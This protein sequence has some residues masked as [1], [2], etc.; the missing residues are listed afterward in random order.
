MDSEFADFFLRQSEDS[1][2]DFSALRKA[3]EAAIEVD[4]KHCIS[5]SLKQL[6]TCSGVRCST[7]GL[8]LKADFFQTR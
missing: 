8:A 1:R 5:A 2:L 4:V 7:C 6:G 3:L